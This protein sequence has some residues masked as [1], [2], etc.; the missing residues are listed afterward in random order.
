M[1]GG[2]RQRIYIAICMSLMPKV[3]MMDEP[4]SALDEKNSWIVME[5]IK[6]FCSRN[7]ITLIVVS[8]NTR[9]AEAFADRTITFCGGGCR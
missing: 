7:G 4:T 3:L 1:L 5:N 9:L 8:H 6:E 2:E